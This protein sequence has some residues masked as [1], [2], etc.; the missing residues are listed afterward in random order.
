[1]AFPP[2]LLASQVN[3]QQARESDHR[4]AYIQETDNQHVEHP[5]LHLYLHSPL[6]PSSIDQLIQ[7]GQSSL[8]NMIFQ[9][10]QKDLSPNEMVIAR[11][12][13][14][15]FYLRLIS[16]G[17]EVGELKGILDNAALKQAIDELCNKELLSLREQ[18]LFLY[19]PSSQ[20]QREACIQPSSLSELSTEKPHPQTMRLSETLNANLHEGLKVLFSVDQESLEV[21]LTIF[22]D[23]HLDVLLGTLKAKIKSGGRVFLVGAGSSGR[24]AIDLAAQWRKN[25]GNQTFIGLMAGGDRA[26][27]RERG[28]CE[29]WTVKGHDQLADHHL[30][31]N[32]VVILI[33]ASGSSAYNEGAASAAKE[34]GAEI[35][36]LYNTEVIAK[37]G[38]M[39]GIHPI[40]LD[41]G[42]QAITGSTRLQATN[43]DKAALG[44]TMKLL[45][46]ELSE[47][48]YDRK[49]SI[50]E[51]MTQLHTGMRKI[52]EAMC[53]IEPIIEKQRD[54]LSS[55]QANF[56]RTQDETESGYIT[57]IGG[58]EVFRQVL[59]DTSEIVPTFDLNPTRTIDEFNKKRA[60]YAPYLVGEESNLE[61]WKTVLQKPLDTSAE[62]R[63]VRQLTIAQSCNAFGS[64]QQRPKG[65]GNQVIAV[66][67]FDR[68]KPETITQNFALLKDAQ[69]QGSH[70]AL[71]AFYSGTKEQWEEG[72]K[73]H[74]E[75][76]NT[77]ALISD[78]PQ[79]N[80]G[81]VDSIC[82]K[83]LLNLISNGTMTLMDKIHGNEMIDVFPANKKL[84]DRSAR[85]IDKIYHSYHNRH[86]DYDLICHYLYHVMEKK[87]RSSVYIPSV[88][89][90]A[91]TMIERGIDF[92]QACD[93][94]K[95][96]HQRIKEIFIKTSKN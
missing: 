9:L 7:T 44:L 94:L 24:I 22:I 40:C 32:D 43:V 36:S 39:Q 1:M 41:V 30:S 52:Q 56:Y 53:Q 37:P 74:L 4:T 95:E 15:D 72:F 89:R 6:Q 19:G 25:T 14:R 85:I 86:L 81:M 35:F 67:D 8:L 46:K 2:D 63:E 49:Q 16:E 21:G 34:V 76:V 83:T 48:S 66:C 65:D 54:I 12:F 27:V 50:S 26:F 77:V 11:L 68:A 87:E 5:D 82:I 84:I 92:D 59:I 80:A 70:T 60:E 88:S 55:P 75:L 61:A 64:Y 96:H 13:N 3:A 31:G 33:S 45:Q 23:K 17:V 62:Q 10:R 69:K 73:G 28:A 47:D 71:I 90:I 93:F 57:Y 51:F 79:D 78:F 38:S 18:R 58:E 42:P 20:I 29:D 91:L